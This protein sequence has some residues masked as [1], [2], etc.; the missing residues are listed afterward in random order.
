MEIFFASSNEHKKKEMQ[1]LFPSVNIILPKEIG[2]DFDPVEDGSSFIENALIKAQ[3]LFDI[4]KLPVLSDDSGLC[5]K[6]LGW[7]PGIHTARYGEKEMGRKLTDREKYE[8]LLSNM[9]EIND[10]EAYFV[11]ALVLICSPWEKYVVQE[12]CKGEIARKA[13]G[14]NGFGYDPV[15]FN[16]EAGMISA[17]LSEEDKNRF[18]HRGKAAR[19][20]NLIIKEVL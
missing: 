14:A 19:K 5:V 3:A 6:A 7:K 13:E 4:V 15:F 9:K 8:Y 12:S 11:S 17:L 18:S 20:M 1:A 2:I 16:S 10:R